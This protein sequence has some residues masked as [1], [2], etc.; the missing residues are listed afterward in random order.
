VG[1]EPGRRAKSDDHVPGEDDPRD[2]TQLVIIA[3]SAVLSGPDS[4]RRAGLGTPTA[5]IPAKTVSLRVCGSDQT[6]PWSER[7][8]I[9]ER[10]GA[11]ARSLNSLGQLTPRDR[12]CGET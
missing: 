4:G 2:C 3:T 9:A 1:D 5:P 10:R 8:L 12:S 6:Y 11:V 7:F